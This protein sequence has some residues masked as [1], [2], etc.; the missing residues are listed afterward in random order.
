MLVLTVYNRNENHSDFAVI[1]TI[2]FLKH[3]LKDV[4]VKEKIDSFNMFLFFLFQRNG[5]E[6]KQVR[7]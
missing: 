7:I 6:Y 5:I 3:Y 4:Q 1:K 2:I